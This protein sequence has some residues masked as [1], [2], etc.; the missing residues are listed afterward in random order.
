MIRLSKRIKLNLIAL[1]LAILQQNAQNQFIYLIKTARIMRSRH[2]N[3]SYTTNSTYESKD[4]DTK[5]KK[6]FIL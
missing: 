1:V 6:I 4:T 2:I 5:Q 3:I